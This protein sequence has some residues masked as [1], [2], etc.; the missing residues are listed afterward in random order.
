MAGD[1]AH[2]HLAHRNVAVV[3]LPPREGGVIP[4]APGGGTGVVKVHC[5]SLHTSPRGEHRRHRGDR[6][7]ACVVRLQP[8][9]L[10]VPGGMGMVGVRILYLVHANDRRLWRRLTGDRRRQRFL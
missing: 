10:P 7:G 1:T 9:L 4:P 8:H 2:A 5:D 3:L 6:G